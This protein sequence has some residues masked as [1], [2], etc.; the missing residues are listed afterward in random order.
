MVV[1]REELLKK[2]PWI[3]GSLLAG[4]QEAN[5]ICQKEYDYPKR[6]SFPTAALILEE[7]EARFGKDPWQHGLEANRH[8]LETFMAYAAN[9]G[10][11]GRQL[12][13]E[14]SLLAGY[15]VQGLAFDRGR[16]SGARASDA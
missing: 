2:E 8:T 7:E 1:V 14:E 3:V 11:T 12:S 6:L 13:L 4:F 5:R 9:Q 15:S 10:Y 16:V